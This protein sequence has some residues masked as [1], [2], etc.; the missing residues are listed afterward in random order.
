[1]GRGN[2]IETRNLVIIQGSQSE[3]K[4]QCKRKMGAYG[5]WGQS[6]E[7]AFLDQYNDSPVNIF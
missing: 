4:L 7:L 2:K 5:D 3:E 6:R 1:M